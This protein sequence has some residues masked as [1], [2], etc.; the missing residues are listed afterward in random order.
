MRNEVT[1]NQFATLIA[2][3]GI[4]Q[5]PPWFCHSI[6]PESN[7]QRYALSLEL[8]SKFASLRTQTESWL[9]LP[10]CSSLPSLMEEKFVC[11]LCKL[12]EKG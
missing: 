6:E 4:A 9:Q 10:P 1:N 5:V 2:A 12:L 8:I 3:L 7:L 11:S